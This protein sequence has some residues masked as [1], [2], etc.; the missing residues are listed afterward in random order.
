MKFIKSQTAIEFLILVGVVL[1]FFTSFFLILGENIEDK[2]SQN[3]NKNVNEIA[4]LVQEEIGFASDSVEGYYREFK[5]PQD[6][7]GLDYEISLVGN[8]VYIKSVNEKYSIALPVQNVSGEIE[9]GINVIQKN[10]GVV[11]L[12]I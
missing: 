2:A 3:I 8:K 4:L 6:I 1:L 9:K 7:N 11:L 10:G 12:N 5:V